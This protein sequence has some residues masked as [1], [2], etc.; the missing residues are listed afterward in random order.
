MWDVT[1]ACADVRIVDRETGDVSVSPRRKRLALVGFATN[2]LHLVPWQ[3]QT[4]ELWSMNQ[5]Y[6]HCERRTDRHFEMHQPEATA[7]VRDPNY[8]TWL[9]QCPIPV[10]MIEAYPVVPQSVRYPIESVMPKTRAR[11]KGR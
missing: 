3:D 9:Q 5:G 4:I 11:P 1:A 2:T 10:Y 7:D 6:M 8:L